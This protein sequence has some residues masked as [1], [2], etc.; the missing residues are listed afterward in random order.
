MRLICTVAAILFFRL[1]DAQISTLAW[2]DLGFADESGIP[3]GSVFVVDGVEIALTWNVTIVGGTFVAYSGD[4]YVS[5]EESEQGGHIGYATLGFDNSHNDP[6]DVIEVVLTF[7]PS[8]TGLNFKILDI[9]AQSWDDGVEVFYNDNTNIKSNPSLYT[10]GS[11]VLDDNETYMDGFE[12]VPP[13]V[14][15]S[16]TDG[17]LNIDFGSENVISVR[18]RY[19]STDDANANPGGQLIGISDIGFDNP[20][21]LHVP[22][23]PEVLAPSDMRVNLYPNPA[24]DQLLLHVPDTES[25]QVR[26]FDVTGREVMREENYRKESPLYIDRL[27]AG[28]YLIR[29]SR[30][31]RRLF[32]SSF[33]K[34][35]Y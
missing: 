10:K 21:T 12:S 31:G 1:A 13:S 16:S 26:I 20:V 18:I 22:L 27:R 9:D 17:N 23:A 25:Y 29:V 7:T 5:F 34:L 11:K 24:L 33:V 8:V 30:M 35:R 15:A 2:E 32:H 6:R 19:F 28:Q 3:S 14:H 4:D